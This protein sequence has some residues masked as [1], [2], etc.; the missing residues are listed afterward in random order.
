LGTGG[1]KK[2]G[3]PAPAAA[4]DGR[5]GEEYELDSGVFAGVWARETLL[6]YGGWDEGWARNQDA[7]LA[8]RFLGAGERL[9]CL[10]QMGAE[11]TPRDSLG[12]LWR[13]YGGYGEYRVKTALRHPHTLRRSHLLPPSLVLAAGAALAAPGPLRRAA[14]V[15]LAVYAVV[16]AA[17]AARAAAHAEHRSDAALVPV[18]L[19]VMHF[20]N[21]VGVLR[22]IARSGPPLA[23]L[24]AAFGAVRV[25]DKLSR[26]T[27][28]VSAPSLV[29]G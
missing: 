10:P 29:G 27:D 14:R 21:G 13:Q 23:A 2:W 4:A 3:P 28:P 25:A 5:D 17:A 11:Y 16:L 26:R 24:A 20:G 9:V 7:E 1:S 22:G 6:G 12:P 18:V 8:G 19:A 15:T